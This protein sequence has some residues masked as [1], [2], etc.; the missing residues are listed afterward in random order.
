M[1]CDA[2]DGHFAGSE[3]RRLKE[4]LT[5]RITQSNACRDRTEPS[6]E[7]E[8]IDEGIP[9]G[10]P[11]VPGRDDAGDEFDVIFPV[12]D[13]HDKF[14]VTALIDSDEKTVGQEMLRED[15]LAEPL[16]N[17]TIDDDFGHHFPYGFRTRPAGDLF[18]RGKIITLCEPHVHTDEPTPR[19]GSRSDNP[20]SDEPRIQRVRT[21]ECR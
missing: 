3:T 12:V 19:I 7:P 20:S 21:R 16:V 4:V 2:I 6:H 8:R 11:V 17:V 9:V 10:G 14:D 18:N 1:P 5:H 15:G 13:H